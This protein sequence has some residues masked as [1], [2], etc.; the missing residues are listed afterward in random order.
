[1]SVDV[2]SQPLRLFPDLMPA[3]PPHRTVGAPQMALA[4]TYFG[5]VDD[6]RLLVMVQFF[7]I[8]QYTLLAIFYFALVTRLTGRVKVLL[9]C[10]SACLPRPLSFFAYIVSPPWK[11]PPLS[12]LNRRPPGSPPSCPSSTAASRALH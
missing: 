1:M 7:K 9:R 11:V 3:P 10:V 4:G 5:A 8:N 12:L 2:V 6:F